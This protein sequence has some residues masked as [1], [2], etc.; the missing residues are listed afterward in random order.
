MHIHKLIVIQAPPSILFSCITKAELI[1]FWMQQ[2]ESIRFP[3]PIDPLQ[4]RG[5]RFTQMIREGLFLRSYEGRVEEYKEYDKFS[6]SFWDRRFQFRLDYNISE[7]EHGTV[8][9]YKLENQREN[10]LTLFAGGLI[11]GMTESMVARN[12]KNLKTFAEA[13]V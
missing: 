4:P 12:L 10:L 13:R 5:T 9:N 8:L 11:S 7:E 3:E 1:P 2:V 6:I